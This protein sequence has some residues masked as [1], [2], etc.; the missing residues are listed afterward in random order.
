MLSFKGT[1][2]PNILLC[3]LNKKKTF[4]VIVHCH[5]FVS[6]RQTE[7]ALDWGW[8]NILMSAAR[9]TSKLF[10]SSEWR[11]PH[12]RCTVGALKDSSKVFVVFV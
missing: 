7:M 9:F 2:N 11:H 5:E 8:R 12:C 1:C 10:S 3:V 6:F 4:C